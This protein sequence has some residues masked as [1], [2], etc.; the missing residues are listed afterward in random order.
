MKLRYCNIFHTKA[1]SPLVSNPRVG[2]GGGKRCDVA[3]AHLLDEG[4]NAGKRVRLTR[5]TRPNDLSHHISDPGHPTRTR[6]KRLHPP[7]SSGAG[8]RDARA[9]QSFSSTWGWVRVASETPGTS[10][11]REQAWGFSVWSV[12][13]KGSVRWH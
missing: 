11:R 12:Q 7:D 6:W 10:L 9:S 3:P 5:K 8:G 1:F 4:S 2:T 13:P